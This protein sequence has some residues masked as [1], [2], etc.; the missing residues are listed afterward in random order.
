[1][2]SI[3]RGSKS[4]QEKHQQA[5]EEIEALARESYDEKNAPCSEGEVIIYP[6]RFYKAV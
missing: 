1:M 6:R 2:R 4:I 3:R 5:E